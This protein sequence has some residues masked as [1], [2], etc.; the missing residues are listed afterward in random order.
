MKTPND[1]DDAFEKALVDDLARVEKAIESELRG[2][3]YPGGLYV[4]RDT[5]R[6][7]L[8]THR[9]KPKAPTF[10]IRHRDLA[11]AL[12]ALDGYIGDR[13][14]RGDLADLRAIG[15]KIDAFADLLRSKGVVVLVDP[16]LPLVTTGSKP[17]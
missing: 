10:E 17:A 8:A 7:V 3:G 4:E 1:L 15:R 2:G 16:D 5:L 6:R 13:E 9:A 11:E 12:D 14:V